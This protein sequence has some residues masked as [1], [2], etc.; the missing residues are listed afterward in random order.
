M[1][2]ERHNNPI[3][4]QIKDLNRH[5]SKGDMQMACKHI[6]RCSTSLVIR[7]MQI[8]T[9]TRYHFASTGIAIIKTTTKQ[10]PVE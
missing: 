6:K 2:Q 10:R 5:L 7:E 4:I 3:K 8:K 9:T 1:Q